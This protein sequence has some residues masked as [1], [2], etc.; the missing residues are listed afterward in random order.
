M[1]LLLLL[2]LLEYDLI[3]P[4]NDIANV[5]LLNGEEDK[6]SNAPVFAIPKNT[7]SV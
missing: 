6:I 3:L 2:L 1:I 4:T 5:I 7:T